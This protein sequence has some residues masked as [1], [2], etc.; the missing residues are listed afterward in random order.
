MFDSVVKFDEVVKNAHNGFM[1]GTRQFDEDDAL[2]RAMALFWRRG[3][4]PTSMQDLAQATGVL[5][6]SLYHAYGDKQALF[7][8]VFARYQERFLG[9]VRAAMEA[10]TPEQ[11]LR[12]YLGFSIETITQVGD[13]VTTRGCLTT[14]T[15]TDETAMNEEI[16]AGLARPA[17]R[18]R[19]LI[20]E[21]LARPDALARLTLTPAAAA[22][23]L[24]ITTTRGMVVLE[25]VYSDRAQLEAV[26]EDLLR[27]LL[28]DKLPVG[29][30]TPPAPDRSTR[31]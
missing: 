7:L 27:V 4:G 3:F 14:K 17:R 28:P 6:G 24:I 1:A 23:R 21:R 2:D 29:R 10:A 9:F 25:R 30:A 18:V 19:G 5:R 15:A 20:E 26:A 11:A 8:R 22:T 31:Q 13:D 12:Q 16:R